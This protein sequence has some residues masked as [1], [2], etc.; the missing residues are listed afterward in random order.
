MTPPPTV[1]ERFD[2]YLSAIEPPAAR[3]EL[4][5]ALPALLRKYLEASTKLRLAEPGTL[6][7]G[8]YRRHTAIQ[9]IKDVDLA[10][11]V[12]PAYANQP[13]EVVMNDLYAAID[14]FSRKEVRRRSINRT[15]QRRSIRVDFADDALQMDAVPVIA[16]KGDP[17]GDLW[18]PDRDWKKW[19]GTR[20]VGYLKWFSSLN[21]KHG[22]RLVSLVKLFKA[23]RQGA[24]IERKEAKAFWLELM[25]VQEVV[26]GTVVMAG[27]PW[28][29]IV[30]TTFDALIR[31]CAPVM[32]TEGACPKVPDPMIMDSNAAA[33]WKRD[34]FE[35]FYMKV[36]TGRSRALQAL[37]AT[38]ES[39]SAS[40]WRAVFGQKFAPTWY[41]PILS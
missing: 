41:D 17:Y 26:D 29:E 37:Q 35:A 14:A 23:W 38:S 20:S 7:V 18:I 9:Q 40:R 4:A 30:V 3:M 8:S 31:R 33:L 39:A 36:I 19:L 22:G 24:L 11:F 21:D 5:Q 27:R 32:R 15:R 34:G 12:D 16:V 6:L 1:A 28:E 10:V 2:T 13:V 25:I